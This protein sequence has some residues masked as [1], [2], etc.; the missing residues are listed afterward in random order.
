MVLNCV[1]TKCGPQVIT[2]WTTKLD[3][4]IAYGSAVVTSPAGQFAPATGRFTPLITGYYKICAYFRSVFFC[5]L[6]GRFPSLPRDFT[7]CTVTLPVL[8]VFHCMCMR[9]AGFGPGTMH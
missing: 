7:V 3:Q 8:R 1:G 9:D 6:R 2:G 5:C 4:L